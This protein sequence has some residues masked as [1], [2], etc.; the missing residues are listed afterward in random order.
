MMG[1]QQ[2]DNTYPF[3]LG[4]TKIAPGGRALLHAVGTMWEGPQARKQKYPDW[5]WNGLATCRAR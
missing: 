1:P 3:D 2:R 4:G 5:F